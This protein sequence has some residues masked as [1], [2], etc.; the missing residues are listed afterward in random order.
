MYVKAA[1]LSLLLAL[2]CNTLSA[3]ETVQVP[4]DAELFGKAS[5]QWLPS[6]CR[7]Q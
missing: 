6:T 1:T 4:Q 5:T 3:S 2:G 7:C